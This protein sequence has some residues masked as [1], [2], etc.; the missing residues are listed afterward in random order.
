MYKRLSLEKL[1][2]LNTG[3]FD[4][5]RTIQKKSWHQ[6]FRGFLRFRFADANR[7]YLFER[8]RPH[9]R[10]YLNGNIVRIVDESEKIDLSLDADA[11]QRLHNLLKDRKTMNMESRNQSII[12]QLLADFA[13]WNLRTIAW[14]KFLVYDI[15]TTIQKGNPTYFEMSYDIDSSHDHVDQLGYSYIDRWA[16]KELAD[17]LLAFD[18]WVIWYN[19]IS[20]DNPVLLKNCGY[21]KAAIEQLNKKSLDPFLIFQK[22]TW[23]RLSLSHVASALVWAWKTLESWAEGQELLKK[24]NQT[25]KE[26]LLTK[27]KEY[28]KNDVEITLWVV[29]YLLAHKKVHFDGTL[30]RLDENDLV[31]LWTYI[32]QQ[33]KKKWWSWFWK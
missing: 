13:W 16:M 25:G 26:S 6:S 32:P 10:F 7:I 28:C 15:E 3:F 2:S 24:Y 30:H 9:M 18:W 23:R 4:R 31:K 19:N 27:V 1:L 29:L 8:N 5:L 12:D 14:K 20:F 17:R 11:I 33:T 21:S 22:I